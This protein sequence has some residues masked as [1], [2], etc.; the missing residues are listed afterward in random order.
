[1]RINHIGD[2]SEGEF[3]FGP[4]VQVGHHACKCFLKFKES[5]PPFSLFLEEIVQQ[6]YGERPN[7]SNH[8]TNDCTQ[9]LACH[10]FSPS[11]ILLY[12]AIFIV[13]V[14]SGACACLPGYLRGRRIEKAHKKAYEIWKKHIESGGDDV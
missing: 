10:I 13:A 7:D 6:K 3:E 11:Q 1:V 4:L 2:A 14:F 8:S 5:V 12:I 9:D